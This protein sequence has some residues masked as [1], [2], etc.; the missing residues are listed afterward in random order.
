MPLFLRIL[1]AWHGISVAHYEND[2]TESLAIMSGM[3]KIHTVE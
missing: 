3:S 2:S 1:L